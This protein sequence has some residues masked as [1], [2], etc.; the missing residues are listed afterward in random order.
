MKKLL[1]SLGTSAL[2]S[3]MIAGVAG[4]HTAPPCNDS[5]GDGLPSGQEYAQHHIVSMAHDGMLGN[6]GHKPGVHHGFS[7]CN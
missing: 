7:V 6:D 4:A 1:V 3:I 2:I 5:D